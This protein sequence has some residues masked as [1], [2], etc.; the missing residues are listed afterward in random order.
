MTA[1]FDPPGECPVCG[2]EVPPAAAACPE[3]GACHAS[4]WSE[5]AAGDAI[6]LPDEEFDY[7]A[8]VAEEFG[9]PGGGERRSGWV[10]LTAAGLI[11][12]LLLW[13]LA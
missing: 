1:R 12:L 10:L 3:C 8:F 13:L 9:P 4:G 5:A 2:T 6:G 11:L 7:Q